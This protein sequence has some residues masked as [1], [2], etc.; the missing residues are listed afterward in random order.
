MSFEYAGQQT[1]A[2]VPRSAL[3]RNGAPGQSA[4]VTQ[5]AAHA[6]SAR[7]PPESCRLTQTPPTIPLQFASIWHGSQ[8]PRPLDGMQL[9]DAST[10]VLPAP[11]WPSLVH[12]TQPPAATSQAGAAGSVQ[13]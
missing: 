4:S 12:P 6:V 8:S 10:Q 5:T 11:Q 2:A 3:Q 7:S 13:F 9:F 1:G